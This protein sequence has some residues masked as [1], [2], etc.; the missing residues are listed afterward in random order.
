MKK[1]ILSVILTCLVLS[2]LTHCKEEVPQVNTNESID[3]HNL[4]QDPD[5]GKSRY[6]PKSLPAIISNGENSVLARILVAAGDEPK[7]TVI[8]LHGNPGYEKNEEIGQ[9]LR[10]GGVNSVFFSYT[11]TWGNKGVFSYGYSMKDLVAVYEYIRSNKTQYRV[12]ESNIFV[13][14][15]S[16]GADIALLAA[17][18]SEG[19]KGVISIDPWNGYHEL[20]SKNEKQFDAYCKNVENRPCITVISG[21]DFSS[22][23]INNERFNLKGKIDQI[24]IP[25]LHIF[26]SIKNKEQFNARLGD[27][28]NQKT[29][30]IESVDHSFSDK[31]IALTQTIYQWIMLHSKQ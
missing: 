20:K 5:I 26:S 18:E 30:L 27:L 4:F 12:D 23:I 14:G 22:E 11:G 10:R 19:I 6:N 9:I 15:F 1:S 31:R 13:C 25:V 2:L 24:N 21:K 17:S 29:E 16:M 28:P 7:P 3:L 8:F